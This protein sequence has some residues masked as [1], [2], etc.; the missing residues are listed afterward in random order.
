MKSKTD[1]NKRRNL[2][3]VLIILITI[4]LVLSAGCSFESKMPGNLRIYRTDTSGTILWN[5]TIVTGLNQFAGDIAESSHHDLIVG[6]PRTFVARIDPGGNVTKKPAPDDQMFLSS[7]ATGDGGRLTT[8]DTVTKLNAWGWKEWDAPVASPTSAIR[9]MNGNYIV[10]GLRD[11][12]NLYY[13]VF[14]LAPN[15]LILWDR[16][17]II[18]AK[19]PST[20]EFWSITSLY[21]SPD[22]VIEVT[23][24]SA[25]GE[26]PRLMRSNL[27]T[28]ATNG[29]LLEV[30]NISAFPPMTRT[31]GGDYVF[32]AYPL[33]NGEG[34]TQDFPH[35]MIVHIIKLSSN[36]TPIWDK[37]LPYSE[38]NDPLSIIQTSDGGYAVLSSVKK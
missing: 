7:I 10:G 3:L 9:L 33:A 17:A 21:E 2:M 34:Y 32:V 18:R 26:R 22:R 20:I 36:G 29:T 8:I 24:T 1:G 4:S 11:K 25:F 5:A 14:C 28:F 27:L 37:E 23:S 35:D 13:Q 16:E 31:P 6:T 15:G 30:K 19:N 38:D 12:N